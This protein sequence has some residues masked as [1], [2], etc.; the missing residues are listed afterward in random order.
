MKRLAVVGFTS[1]IVAC[2]P[3]RA[4]A[5]AGYVVKQR[6]GTSGRLV[7]TVSGDGVVSL[8]Y[9]RRGR[10]LR[11]TAGSV[12]RYRDG[13]VFLLDPARR[14][15]RV[16]DLSARLRALA[17]ERAMVRQPTF[18]IELP[19]RPGTN[20]RPGRFPRAKA[21]PKGTITIAG[22]TAHGY[23]LRQGSTV[24][25]LWFAASL[26]A[27]PA[28]LRNELR[29]FGMQGGRGS[30]DRALRATLGEVLLRR[31]VKRGRRWRRTLDTIRV[32]R[33]TVS[34]STFR[35]P[36]GY[37]RQQN[38]DVETVRTPSSVPATVQRGIGPVAG[39]PEV[40]ALY[41]G[42]AFAASP[43]TVG[44][45]NTVLG[46]FMTPGGFYGTTYW[47]GLAQYGIVPSTF[48]GSAVFA[49]NPP[50]SV[51][52]ANFIAAENL[53]TRAWLTTAAPKLWWGIGGHD[54]ILAIFVP[55]A[56]VDVS[57]WAGYHAFALTPAAFLPWPAW[58]AV[59]P[60]VPWLIV[61]VPTVTPTGGPASTMGSF[62]HELLEAA[63]DPFPFTSWFDPAKQPVWAEAELADICSVSM[64]TPPPFGAR[65][66]LISGGVP[67]ATY[68]SQSTGLCVPESRP[69]LTLQFPKEGDRIRR[70]Q[71][72]YGAVGSDPLD[73]LLTVSWLDSRDGVLPSNSSVKKDM[74][75]GAHTLTA[76]V[77]DSQGM[78][79]TRTVNFTIFADPPVVTLTSPQPGS[80]FSQGQSTTLRASA[81]DPQDG[82]LPSGALHWTLDG[83][84]IANGSA[85]P[86]TFTTVGDHTLAV[87]ATNSAG[88]KGSASIT[89]HVVA[90]ANNPPFAQITQ[91]ADGTSFGDGTF[92]PITFKATAT[93]PEDGTIPDP[94]VTWYDSYGTVNNAV[95][96][97]GKQM[98]TTLVQTPEDQMNNMMTKHTITVVA[99]DSQGLQASDTIVVYV[100]VIIT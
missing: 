88:I 70:D 29:R 49:D 91:P 68:W 22:V 41:W 81:V 26:P 1:L 97:H 57:G 2:L 34:A 90:T 61:K 80:T 47:P 63:S 76:T 23:V 53:V 77:T 5:A 46:S 18:A 27:P 54:P 17:R 55:S 71:F 67:L 58:L 86:Y 99:E 40:F 59:R 62:S 4:E 66:R 7:I 45:M 14:R 11:V 24:E 31:E 98:S 100:G 93:D 10:R 43:G 30:V 72:F 37:R 78:S 89:V 69:S 9:T 56:A 85:A 82:T 95:L 12:V 44:A 87:F 52:S 15:Y 39:H 35:P 25:R 8:G 51:G 21:R 50:A 3:G 75:L 6:Q 28:A 79:V 96:G 65:T 38:A 84:L 42:A 36:R 13:R 64:G 60:A 94:K 19:A 32:T 48:L 92:N 33:R 20:P 83:T 16:F 74:S 73:G